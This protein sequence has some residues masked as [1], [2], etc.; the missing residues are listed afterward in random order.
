MQDQNGYG[1]YRMTQVSTASGMELVMMLYDGLINFLKDAEK[2]LSEGD[3]NESE[4]LCNRSR[5]IIVELLASLSPDKGGEI[6]ENLQKLYLF[7]LRQLI[8]AS[9]KKETE[10]IDSVIR[11]V[12]SLREGW[13][14]IETTEPL[15][16][17]PGQRLS[18][19]EAV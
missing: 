16:P 15:N 12:S 7:S 10:Y 8:N 17:E 14:N 13:K 9:I 5:K 4:R 1:I 2:A 19:Q 3:Y 11:I 6:A 18:V